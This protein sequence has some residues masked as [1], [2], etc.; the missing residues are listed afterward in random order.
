ML[1]LRTFLIILNYLNKLCYMKDGLYKQQT[2][3]VQQD[4]EIHYAGSLSESK[5]LQTAQGEGH[6]L[7]VSILSMNLDQQHN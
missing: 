1:C 7:L 2:R 3:D 6:I 4:A 5:I